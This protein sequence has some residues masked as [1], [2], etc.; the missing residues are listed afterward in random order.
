MVEFAG[1]GR[2]SVSITD[3]LNTST[4]HASPYGDGWDVL[5]LGHCGTKFPP[6]NSSAPP[7]SDGTTGAQLPLLRV[8]IPDDETVPAA[9]HLKPHPF[10]LGDSLGKEYAPY[11]RVV[12]ASSSTTCTQAYAVT[13][14]GAKK[15]LWQFGLETFTNGFDLM[16]RDFCEGK[17]V[18]DPGH[19]K[20]ELAPVC[21]TVQPP[22][23]SHFYSQA[24][25]SDIQGQG[26]G[27]VGKTGSPYVR[28]SVRVNLGKLVI[29]MGE[30]KLDDQWP[31]DK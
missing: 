3:G 13:Q 1:D 6:V 28:L 19:S 24:G 27:F 18:H 8:T 25:G 2:I 17:Y 12:H 20:G 7:S 31:D 21:L 15:L 29:G 16:L 30:N 22:L 23:F 26:G 5:W 11:T 9:K 10:A 4:P 14:K